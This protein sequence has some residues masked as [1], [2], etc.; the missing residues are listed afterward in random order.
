[1]ISLT[2]I[3]FAYPDALPVFS[4]FS[5][6]VQTGERWVILG[7]SG[8]GKSTLLYLLAGLS[9]PAAGSI[10]IAGEMQTATRPQTGLILQDYGLLPWA[11]AYDNVALGMNIRRFYGPDDK[12]VPAN[13]Q[14]ERY[15]QKVEYWMERLRLMPHAQKYPAQLSGG[16]RQRVAI[17]RTLALGPDL[18]LMDEPFSSL[19][20]PTREGLQNLTMKLQQ[21]EA[22]TAVIVTHTI[23]EAAVLGQKIL[24]L[25]QP[26]HHQPRI[27]DN[28]QAADPNFRRQPAYFEMCVKIRRQ[29]DG[30][31]ETS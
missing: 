27:L 8:C 11:T 25:G 18:L 29:M 9:K 22:L 13:D 7:P 5:W 2:N 17:A 14:P 12:H 21:E 15:V 24:L 20:A 23:E 4:Q 26:P 28:P 3:T 30:V 6:Q 19:D 1:M 31:Y 10:A 16:Q